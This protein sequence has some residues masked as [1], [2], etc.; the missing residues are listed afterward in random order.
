MRDMLVVDIELVTTIVAV[1]IDITIDRLRIRILEQI[2]G[3][4]ILRTIVQE[5][6][7]GLVRRLATVG[8]IVTASCYILVV[9]TTRIVRDWYDENSSP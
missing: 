3:Q 1:H 8:R 2:L 5:F 7:L 9:G 4:E 6:E